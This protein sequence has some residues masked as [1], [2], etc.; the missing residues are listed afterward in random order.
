MAGIKSLDKQDR[1]REKLLAKGVKYLTDLEL[2][3]VVIGSGVQGA[4]VV[5]I[6]K[7][8]LKILEKNNG[9]ATLDELSEI[10]G[11]STAT[12]SKM[13]AS[14]ELTSRFV[15]S[16]LKL[17]SSEDILPLVADLRTKK[18]EHFVTITIDGGNRVIQRRLISVG[19]LNASLVHPRDVFSG[20]LEDNA[21]SII[22]VHN[23]PSSTLEPSQ[24]D[25]E[26][27]KRLKEAGKLFGIN[28]IDHFI[29][30]AT[31]HIKI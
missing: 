25:I 30:T 19:T 1:P 10:K 15:K 16:G 17:N 4:D 20:A 6:S 2:L 7:E 12:A 13:V 8:T 31:E 27:T 28:L 3:Q 21:A 5:K 9:Q 29:I 26:V 23:H 22:L 18:Q 24:A 11:V 14:L